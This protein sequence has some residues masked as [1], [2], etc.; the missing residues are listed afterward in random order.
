MLLLFWVSPPNVFQN[1]LV[2]K[3][4][5]TSDYKFLKCVLPVTMANDLVELD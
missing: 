1:I 2:S 3:C 4:F 5:Y